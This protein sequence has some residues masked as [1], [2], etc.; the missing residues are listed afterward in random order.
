MR[1]R[2]RVP[3]QSDSQLHSQQTGLPKSVRAGAQCAL[4]A[5]TSQIQW[6][7]VWRNGPDAGVA[8]SL[9]VGRHF[10]GRAHTAGFRCDDH[11]LLPH[12]ALI[13][14]AADGTVALTQLTGRSPLRVDGR[15][16]DAQ[17]ELISDSVVEIGI[18]SFVLLDEVSLDDVYG[19]HQSAQLRAG[20]LVRA[21]RTVSQLQAIELRAPGQPPLREASSGGLL[22]AMLGLA[23]AGTIAMVL[24]QPMF[25]LFGALGATVA[26]GSWVA[27]R[28]AATRK[29][30]VATGEFEAES[31]T[32]QHHLAL[33]HAELR[34]HTLATV[35]TVDRA[36]RTLVARNASLWTRRANHSDAYLVAIGMNLA[37]IDLPVSV[38]VGP[39]SRI[40]LLG[41]HGSAVARS[42]IVQLAAACGPA[43]LRITIAT[44]HPERWDSVRALPHVTLPD[45][46]AAV[47]GESALAHVLDE[48]AGHSAHGGHH[49]LLT[50]Q[51]AFL[52]TR[53]SPLRRA[54]GDERR[55]ALIVVVPD[56]DPS[57][58]AAVPHVCRSVLTTMSGPSARW[59]PDVQRTM[60][61]L[62]VRLVGVGERTTARC[63]ASVRGLI[64]P[65]DPLSVASAV[66]RELSLAALLQ[67]NGNPITPSV[68]AASWAA[69]GTDPAPRTA[70]GVAADG[71]VDIDLVR[72]GPH[73]LIAGTTGSGKSELLRSLV[74][75][76]A[77]MVSPEHLTFVLVD[78]KGG[79]TFDACAALPHVVG[80]V[81]DLDDQLAD[82]AL[83]SLHAELRRREA[84]LRE[85][86]VA[87]LS[88]LRARSTSATLPRLVVVIDEFAAL[89][90]EQPS[91]LHALVGIAQR[92]RSLGVHLL[93]AT[94]RPNGVITD[95]IRANT[96]LRLALR[97]QDTADAI[98]VVGIAAPAHLPRGIPGRAVLRL[99][100]DDHLTF[101]TAQCT[102]AT[103]DGRDTELSALVRT[104]CDA[105]RMA[106]LA[107]ANAPWMP[108]LPAMILDDE[109]VDDAG[110]L[111]LIDEPD[112]QRTTPLRWSLSDGRLAVVGS[113]GSGVTSTLLTVAD[114]TLSGDAAVD[115]YVVDARGDQRWSA[116][117][118]HP[119]CVA[120]VQLHE[121][122]RLHRLLH[123][124]QMQVRSPRRETVAT[125][126]IVDGLDALRRT[127]DD[128]ETASEYEALEQI[129]ADGQTAGITV[130]AGAESAAALPVAFLNRCPARWVLHLHDAHDAAL[131]GVAA[132]HVPPAV[133][134]RIVIAGSDSMAQVVSPRV[135]SVPTTS[136]LTASAAHPI[137]VV[138]AHVGGT[139]LPRSCANDGV[140]SLYLGIEFTTGEPFA[141]EVP[142]GEHVLLVGVARSGRSTGLG[143][144]AA[145]WS[146]AHANCWVG[147]ILPRRSTFPRQLSARCAVDATAIAALLDELTAHLANGPALLVIDDAESVE[148][149]GARLATLAMADKG[150]CI[151]AAGRPDALRQTYGHWSGV[152]RRSRL[153]LVATGG[154]DLDA[155]LLSVQVPRRTPVPARPGLWWI[156]DGGPARLMQLAADD[157]NVADSAGTTAR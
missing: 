39:G 82:R 96:N 43:D 27:Q 58:D 138:P 23:G 103:A 134:G 30:R 16:T 102:S 61:P 87:D 24:Q 25:L 74:V 31:A 153:G 124:L 127:L 2:P 137:A 83:R 118:A 78:Y 21:P 154:N 7:A 35:A 47:V 95:D 109:L 132:K 28:I 29:L 50:D 85:H 101:Q 112:L 20:A 157:R 67:R 156:A 75:G 115:V 100:A 89:V 53:T 8:V 4:M 76:M 141:L 111:G 9:P 65:E 116:V 86:G 66:P 79:A 40:A 60:L 72:D 147:A 135:L 10:V 104:I 18:S 122:E 120:V 73:G 42:L 51:P 125:L 114:Q 37:E 99:G 11:A 46:T 149:A 107:P 92:G 15:A 90:A 69:A 48:L 123:R 128:V 59:V 81:T 49:L 150:L 146:Q 143:R 108:P 14:V 26:I 106:G 133:P 88:E 129:L 71:V 155:D 119:R 38:D 152:L 62:Q 12:H 148:D 70:I 77:A 136:V 98:D 63:S 117:E 144:I 45:G 126:L 64:D 5:E 113:A 36:V 84:L 44:D 52:A 56:V 80:M 140:T 3:S 1:D 55:D 6:T 121:S 57:A 131:L 91:F 13:E 17:T 34:R 105:A 22:P 54:I 139:D 94:Q 19:A 110:A 97:L 130:V 151:A 93:L 41:P 33:Q 142:D 68:I 145:A 32:Y